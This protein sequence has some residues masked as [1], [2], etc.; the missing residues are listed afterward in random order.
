MCHFQIRKNGESR[1]LRGHPA[2]K[3]NS[4]TCQSMNG[5]QQMNARQTVDPM[6]VQL[7]PEEQEE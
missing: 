3:W 7:K 1:R 4:R 6:I 2:L 5:A